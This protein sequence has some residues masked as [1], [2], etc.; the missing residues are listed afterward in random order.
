MGLWSGHSTSIQEAPNGIRKQEMAIAQ[1][2]AEREERKIKIKAGLRRGEQFV[3]E[4]ARLVGDKSADI[5]KQ[6]FE[7]GGEGMRQQVDFTGEQHMI[8]QM[9]GQGDKIWGVNNEP[10]RINHDLNSSRA[11]PFDETGALFGFGGQSE[12]S[13]LF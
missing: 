2:I 9:F 7:I 11:D 12:R 10:V 6:G 4:K 8:G 3:G 13:G 1:S 5:V